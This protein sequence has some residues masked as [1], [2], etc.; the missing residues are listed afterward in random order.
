MSLISRRNPLTM[1]LSVAVAVLIGCR[2]PASR[3]RSPSPCHSPGGARISDAA[4]L[5][6]SLSCARLSALVVRT[7]AMLSI[8]GFDRLEE[9]DGDLV[10]G[11]TVAV[12]IV[13]MRK[14]VRIGGRLRISGNSS[15]T[16][17][18][19]PRLRAAGR[20]EI[21]YNAGLSTVSM[22]ALTEVGQRVAVTN[23]PDL[24]ALS[25]NALERAGELVLSS[26]PKLGVLQL[27]GLRSVGAWGVSELPALAAEEFAD[28]RERVVVSASPVQSDSK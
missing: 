19:L 13:E 6:A 12:D 8:A 20:V 3:S 4:D 9:I 2:S 22:P 7:G 10:I 15:L 5:S 11:P 1:A 18:F 16:G 28:L 27:D 26:L 25:M 17:V 24:E 21:E 23:N 14:L